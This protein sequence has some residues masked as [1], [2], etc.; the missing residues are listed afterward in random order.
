MILITFG[1]AHVH[2][3]NNHTLD[4]NC[5]AV[6]ESREKA[7]ELFGDKFATSYGIERLK[8]YDFMQHFPRGVIYV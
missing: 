7:F 1:Q 3:V 6:V 4:F 2:C 8:D 5:V